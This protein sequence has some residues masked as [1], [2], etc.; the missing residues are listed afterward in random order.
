MHEILYHTINHSRLTMTFS[1]KEELRRRHDKALANVRQLRKEAGHLHAMGLWKEAAK[2][3]RRA[4]EQA[5]KALDLIDD[6][7]P[8]QDWW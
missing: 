7:N 6:I 3:D 1:D 5:R 8:G 2:L 4:N